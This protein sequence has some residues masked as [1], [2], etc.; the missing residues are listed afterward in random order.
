VRDVDEDHPVDP[1]AEEHGGRAGRRSRERRA[2]Q[3]HEAERDREGHQRRQGAAH[4]KPR[5]PEH[6][7]QQRQNQHERSHGVQDALPS[8]LRF[9][10]DRDAVSAR[11]RD[12]EGRPRLVL[13]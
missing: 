13:A 3:S 8:D 4:E 5:A 7:V 1:Q 2:P 6:E 9:R 12:F 10:F 11:E